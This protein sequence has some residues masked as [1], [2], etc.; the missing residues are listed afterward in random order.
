LIEPERTEQPEQTEQLAKV[1]RAIEFFRGS[2]LQQLWTTSVLLK[3]QWVGIGYVSFVVGIKVTMVLL[4]YTNQ[5]LASLDVLVVSLAIFVIG[6]FLFLL[7]PTPGAPVYAII[8]IVV[9]AS[10]QNSGWPTV[11]GIIWA[12]FIGSA[13]KMAF[14]AIAQKCIGEPLAQSVTVRNLVQVHTT[15]LRAI[16]M[17]LKEPDI[18][19]AKVSILIGGPDWPVAVLC[20]ILRLPLGKILLAT[21]PV[22]LQSVAPC[23]LSGSLLIIFADDEKKKALGE[24]AVAVAGALQV[25]AM[26]AAGYYIQSTIELNYDTLQ[27]ERPQDHDVLALE[28]ESADKD[29]E[30]QERTRLP[31]LPDYVRAMLLAGIA[32]SYTSCLLLAGPWKMFWGVACFRK[33][34]ITSTVAEALGGNPLAMVLPLGWVAIALCLLSTGLL[35]GFHSWAQKQAHTPPAE[36]SG[37]AYG[38]LADSATPG[39]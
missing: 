11:W 26:I 14:C 28:K 7:P 16:E 29:A 33:F 38:I 20:G 9:T 21:S 5:L 36:Q 25:A 18:T 3:A 2:V 24:T 1:W 35:A 19:I 34:E 4:A 13:V 31:T 27:E 8:G 10:A 15:E 39:R 22:L 17:V 12:I 6:V 23:I 30:F 32:S 37:P